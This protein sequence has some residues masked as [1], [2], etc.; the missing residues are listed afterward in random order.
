MLG[1]T[2]LLLDTHTFDSKQLLFGI[3]VLTIAKKI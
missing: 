3:H 2:L 1:C